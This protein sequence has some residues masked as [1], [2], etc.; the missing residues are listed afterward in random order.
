MP[1]TLPFKQLDVFTTVPYHGN[2]VAV[3]N[4]LDISEN[5]IDEKQM[6]NIARWT[7]LSETTFIFKP[8]NPE[9]DYKLRIF[10]PVNELPF[11]GHPTLGSCKAFLQFTNNTTSKTVRQECGLGIVNLTVNED[12]TISYKA[13]STSFDKIDPKVIKEYTECLGVK[14]DDEPLLLHVGPEWVV[15]HVSD[16]DKCY[17]ANPDF[18][19]LAEISKRNG[20]IGIILGGPRTLDPHIEYEMR[21]LAPVI[22]VSEDPVCGSG[23]TALIAY[24]QNKYKFDKTTKL[25]ITQGGRVGRVGRIHSMIEINEAKQPSF[26]SGGNVISLINGEITV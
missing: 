18:A 23:S 11:A 20:H 2:P 17:N 26:H 14:P 25:K 5:D 24:L 6:Q 9:N 21:A 13:A 19:K 16:S 3:I 4:C 7:N 1:I 22:N 10:S 8:S 15:F 12:G